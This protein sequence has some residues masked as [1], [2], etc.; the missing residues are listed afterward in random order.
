MAPYMH[1]HRSILKHCQRTAH[2]LYSLVL[3]HRQ[4]MLT[5]YTHAHRQK[6]RLLLLWQAVKK[7]CHLL[8]GGDQLGL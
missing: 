1:H 5:T 3:L 6:D 2:R 7:A 4:H 8:V